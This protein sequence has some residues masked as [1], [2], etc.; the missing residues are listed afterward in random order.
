MA[1]YRIKDLSNTSFLIEQEEVVYAGKQ[2]FTTV[3]ASIPVLCNSF[4]SNTTSIVLSIPDLHLLIDD[5]FSDHILDASSNIFS[6]DIYVSTPVT[7]YALSQFKEGSVG[8]KDSIAIASLKVKNYNIAAN[9]IT[10]DTISTTNPIN[11]YFT[12]LPFYVTVSQPA[13]T[14]NFSNNVLYVKG[15]SKK[16]KKVFDVTNQSSGVYTANIA[17]KTATSNQIKLFVDDVRQPSFTWTSSNNTTSIGIDLQGVESRIELEVDYYTTPAIEA[18]DVISFSAFSNVFTVSNTSYTTS[19]NFYDEEL[20]DAQVYKVKLSQPITSNVAGLKIVNASTDL[21]GKVGNLTSNSFTIDYDDSYPYSYSLANNALYYVYQKNKLKTTKARLDEFGNL[22]TASPGY[23]LVGATNINRFN[24]ASSTTYKLLEIAPVKLGKVEYIN[25]TEQV[26]IDTTGGASI[27]ATIEFPPIVGADVTHYDI[28]YYI[29]SE[30]ETVASTTRKITVDNDETSEFI[31]ANINNLNRGRTPGSNI[32]V[33]TVVPKNGVY[34][35]YAL[36]SS[37]PLIG[38][39]TPPSGLKNFNIGQQGDSIIFSWQFVLTADGYIQDIDTNEVEVREYSG[40]I[41]TSDTETVEAT[42]AISVP[43]ERIPFP[44]TTFTMPV[45]KFGNYTYLL[46]V[47]DTSDL[48]SE[49]IAAASINIQRPSTVR[50]FKAYSEKDPGVSFI[51]QDGVS[52]PNSNTHPEN[53]F[54]SVSMSI[55]DGLVLSD[56]THVD[57]ANGSSS[58]FSFLSGSLSTLNSDRAVY[59]T[60]IRD[61]GVVA[62]GSIRISTEVSIVNPNTTFTSQYSVVQSGI[63]D[64]PNDSVTVLVDNAFSGIGHILGFSNSNAAVVSYN[65]FH[66]TLTSG[67]ALGNVYAIRNPGQVADDLANTN[68]FCLIAGV[69]NSNAIALGES[70]HAN[71]YPTGSNNFGNV[72]LSGNSYELINLSQFGD[73]EGSLTYIGEERSIVQNVFLRY[74]ADNVF[75]EASANGITGLPGHGNT[76]PFAFEGASSNAAAGFRKYVSGEIDFRYFQIQYEVL[77]KKPSVSS[78]VIDRFDYEVD[79]VEKNINKTVDVDL[80]PGVT[81]DYTYAKLIQTPVIVATMVNS[82]GGYTPVVENVT[83]V[84]CNVKVYDSQS[85]NLVDT[86]TV[87]LLIRGI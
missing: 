51:T 35:G 27:T 60:Q 30:E 66:K 14:N 53:T 77:N 52:F 56:S 2:G 6:S 48:E 39:E 11:D 68:A 43:I 73:L 84:S 4:S 79:I 54:P 62:R 67:G 19:D 44:N 63:T 29:D 10:V 7:Q 40:L 72:A 49:T 86:E 36:T 50:L 87:N 13:T 23:Y 32:L 74:S 12:S 76:N 1:L 33:V 24:R 75:Y 70:F 9:T 81:V 55:N 71:G 38:K 59:T 41:D 78:V 25:I 85:S 21:V 34:S 46:R 22:K 8:Y 28:F 58:G 15:A 45:S 31:T 65:S 5:N 82:T 83:N 61:I 17:V 69:I 16:I 37:K 42:W 57:N 18:N 80:A 26:F 64:E 20:T 47:I 3:S